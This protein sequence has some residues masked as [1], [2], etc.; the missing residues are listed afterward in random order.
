MRQEKKLEYL[1]AHPYIRGDA[2]GV[3]SFHPDFPDHFP[4]IKPGYAS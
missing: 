1:N 3:A 2:N 4:G